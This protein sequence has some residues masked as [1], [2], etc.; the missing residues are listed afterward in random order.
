MMYVQYVDFSDE[1]IEIHIV[2]HYLSNSNHK[3]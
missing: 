3:E 1:V 2:F